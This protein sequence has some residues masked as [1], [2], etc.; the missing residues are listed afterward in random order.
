M[1][2]DNADPP[3][4]QTTKSSQVMRGQGSKCRQ[5]MPIEQEHNSYLET[6]DRLYY[7]K[8]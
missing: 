6:G 5:G 3:I 4:T 2:S 8:A 1:R 7:N